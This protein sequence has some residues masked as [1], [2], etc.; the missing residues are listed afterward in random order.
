MGYYTYFRIETNIEDEV[1]ATKLL[2]SIADIS[3]NFSIALS[4]EPLKWY[5][6]EDDMR[7]ISSLY[8]TVLFTITGEGEDREDTWKARIF[9]QVIDIAESTIV[10]EE[11]KIL[12]DEYIN[13]S[14]QLHSDPTSDESILHGGSVDGSTDVSVLQSEVIANDDMVQ[15][16]SLPEILSDNRADG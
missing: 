1:E 13:R 12:T 7:Y 4:G 9:N 8:P 16:S 5:E 3:V 6:W 14:L 11:H 15:N 2:N 10:F